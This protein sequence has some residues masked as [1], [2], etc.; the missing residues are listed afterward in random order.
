M[1]V[2]LI[3]AFPKQGLGWVVVVVGPFGLGVFQAALLRRCLPV[4][5]VVLWPL[6]T[7]AGMPLSTGVFGWFLYPLLGLGFG[8]AQS[9]LLAA[10]GFRRWLLWPVISGASWFSALMAWGLGLRKVF[11]Q[12]TT[13]RDTDGLTWVWVVFVYA[14]GTG[15]ALRWMGRRPTPAS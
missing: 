2:L 4:W 15:L 3:Q 5:A 13:D 14:L 7:A 1:A 10:G 12:D 6:A 8:L 11:P 9:G